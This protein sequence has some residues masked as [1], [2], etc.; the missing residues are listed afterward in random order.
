MAESVRSALAQGGVLTRNSLLSRLN[1]GD[2]I[3][4]PLL[5]REKQV[6]EGSIDISLGTKFI[7]SQ[8]SHITE[9][10]PRQLDNEQIRE[11]Q[12]ATVTTFGQKL[13]LHPHNF[14]LG[15]TFE[16]VRMPLDLCGFVLSRSAYGRAGL[17]IA[18]A[19]FVHPGWQGCLTLELENLGDVPIILR[20]LTDVGQLVIIH[21]AALNESPKLKS[22]PVGPAFTSLSQDTRWKK[23]KSLEEYS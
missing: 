11:F 13:T 1:S 9:I 2:L 14:V 12:R 22:I 20:P 4:S 18:T 5:D 6:G 17:L 19:T 8:R 7:T 21:S 23:L 10:D 16:F 15:C 3:V